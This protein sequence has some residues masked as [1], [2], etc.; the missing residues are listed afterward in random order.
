MS[1]TRKDP[2]ATQ[3]QHHE[4]QGPTSEASVCL[5]PEERRY[6]YLFDLKLFI[7]WGWRDDPAVK[8][9]GC[10]VGSGSHTNIEDKTTKVRGAKATLFSHRGVPELL[11]S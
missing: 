11:I 8:S 3:A 6:F 9:T 1:S 10:V 4:Q 2:L 7:Y 5:S